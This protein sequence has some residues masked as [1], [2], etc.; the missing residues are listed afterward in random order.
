MKKKPFRI[1]PLPGMNRP[2]MA[3]FN[4]VVAIQK[5]LHKEA[6]LMTSAILVAHLE[7]A[8]IEIDSWFPGERAKIAALR[9]QPTYVS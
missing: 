2:K 6:P 9:G 8:E 4:R 1:Q 5:Q 7:R 3:A